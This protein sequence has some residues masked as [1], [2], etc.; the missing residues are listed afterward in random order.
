MTNKER[1][2]QQEKIRSS[3]EF[4][5]LKMYFGETYEVADKL[6]IS[7]PTFGQIMDIGEQ[8]FYGTLGIFISNSTGYRLPLWNL[9]IDW[10]KTVDFEM[11]QMIY[12]GIDPKIS[13]MLFEK[14]KGIDENGET[15]MLD[16]DFSG[17]E[18]YTRQTPPESEGAE[19]TEEV[20]LYNPV[21][22][23][24]IDQ[25]I[26][27][28]MSQ[29]LRTMFNIFPKTER[30]KGRATKEAIIWE[31]EENAK[32]KKD[33]PYRSTLLPIVSSLVNHPGFKYKLEE[34]RD[35]TMVQ[36]MDSV[37]RLQI[38]ESATALMKGMY[39]GFVDSS[40]IKAENYNFMR[41][42]RAEV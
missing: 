19:P 27:L 39:S 9:G 8:D 12:K 35:L 24:V 6:V 22:D 15:S 7:Q 34:M 13:S 36:I 30:A 14:I 21:Q 32:K 23:I 33:E 4:D 26:Y 18:V 42:L 38:Y 1:F 31:E 25:N 3:F 11:F 28:K 2:E 29:Y 37:Q 17:F 41:D 16:V 40:K 20:V 10:N 5:M